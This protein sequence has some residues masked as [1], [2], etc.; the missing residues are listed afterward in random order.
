MDLETKPVM[1]RM[2]S[3]LLSVPGAALVKA[4]SYLH[5]RVEQV[6]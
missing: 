5:K 4:F 6:A 2:L 3:R 1:T